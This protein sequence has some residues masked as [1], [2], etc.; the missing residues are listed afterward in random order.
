M[1]SDY[2]N[3]C[4]LQ[5]DM[6]NQSAE[7]NLMHYTTLLS[8]LDTQPDLLI[9]PEM[10][11]TGFVVNTVLQAERIEGKS[12][13]FLKQCAKKY[14]TA[15]VASLA[16]KENRHYYN[17]LFWVLPNGEFYRYDKRHLFKMSSE[18]QLFTQ[19][20]QRIIVEYKGWRFLPL[21][22]Y[23]LR[24]PVWSRNVRTDDEFLY[25]CLL[26][27][28][29]W[30]HSRMP[31]YKT[32]LSARAI[33]N[34]SFAISANRVGYDGNGTYHSGG[35]RVVNPFGLVLTE[36]NDK[37]GIIKVVLSKEVLHKHRE[38]FPVSLDWDPIQRY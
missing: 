9:F 10:F 31:V 2:L 22:C 34:Q 30:P 21:I 20:N 18:E 6:K 3:V 5:T 11:N 27:I 19:G 32:L 35:S 4:I 33:E 38:E 13:E 14:Q 1:K 16:I 8:R 36:A 17:S 15:V 29:N 37:E 12:V 23:D 25:D 24:F 26:Y 7:Q 28:S